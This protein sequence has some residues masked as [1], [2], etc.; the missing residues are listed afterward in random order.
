MKSLIEKS[1][2]AAGL[3]KDG[4]VKIASLFKVVLF[5][6][7][8]GYTRISG[9]Y[10]DTFALNL[11]KKH[12]ELLKPII[13]Q[14]N[15]DYIKSTGDGLLALFNNP[16]QAV[17]ASIKMQKNIL[18]YNNKTEEKMDEVHIRIGINMGEV[19]FINGDPI[20]DTVNIAGRVTNMKVKGLPDKDR[21]LITEVVYDDVKEIVKCHC[22]GYRKFKNVLSKIQVYEVKWSR[23]HQ[24]FLFC[25][26]G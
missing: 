11:R 22:L 21:I 4:E 23:E 16:A 13:Q 7:I 19:K 1:L 9:K 20:G 8:E 12:D 15:G 6:D 17:Q 26:K 3:D 25:S 5:T 18:S 14:Y 2:L 24:D 10:G